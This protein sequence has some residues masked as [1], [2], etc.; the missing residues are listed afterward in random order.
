VLYS[1][2]QELK[3]YRE[4]EA[5]APGVLRFI[6]TSSGRVLTDE[7]LAAIEAKGSTLSVD[8]AVGEIRLIEVNG[9]PKSLVQANGVIKEPYCQERCD[10]ELYSCLNDWCDPRGDSCSLC[11][12][13]YNDCVMMCPDV[14]TDPRSVTTYN[15]A[16]PVAVVGYYGSSCRTNL[17]VKSLW[18]NIT[19][20]YRIDTYERSENCDGSYSDR[21]VTSYDQYHTCWNNTHYYCSYS[22]GTPPFPRC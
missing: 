20:R 22:T 21:W 11:Y 10:Q 2:P 16:T 5:A 15:T 7:P 8:N 14:C 17:G 1:H 9:P 19:V 6:V 13:W 4:L 18:E 3:K 12:I